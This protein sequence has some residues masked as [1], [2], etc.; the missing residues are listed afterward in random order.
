M[1]L[2][3]DRNA[4][5]YQNIPDG[6]M[7]TQISIRLPKPMLTKAR[8]TAKQEGY[9]SVQDFIRE[10][11]REKLFDD[12][13]LTPKELE[14]VQRLAKVTEERGDYV[15]EEELREALK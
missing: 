13:V 7:N 12:D 9:G 3:E 1:D 15:S 2:V 6:T 5:K 11:V 10:T 8:Q 4:L 14:L